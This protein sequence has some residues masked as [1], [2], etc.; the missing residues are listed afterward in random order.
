MFFIMLILR[1]LLSET[2]AMPRSPSR[3]MRMHKGIARTMLPVSR[4][5][6]PRNTP[7]ALEPASPIIIVLGSAL[8]QR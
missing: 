8:Y 3:R 7:I 4:S 1:N 6:I 2:F 5:A